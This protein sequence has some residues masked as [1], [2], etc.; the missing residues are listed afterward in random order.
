ME[1]G[2]C[3]ALLEHGQAKVFA[4]QCENCEEYD[5]KSKIAIQR[6]GGLKIFRKYRKANL[7]SLTT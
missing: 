4:D 1:I 5:K 7:I 3:N 2:L 6:V